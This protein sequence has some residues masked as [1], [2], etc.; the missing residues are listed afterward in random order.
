MSANVHAAKGHYMG[1]NT[2]PGF[3]IADNPLDL[4]SIALTKIDPLRGSKKDVLIMIDAF[5]K[6]R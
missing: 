5:L 3:L 2:Q 4:Q 1:P 6:F